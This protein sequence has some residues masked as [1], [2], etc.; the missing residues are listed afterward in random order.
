[1]I[2]KHVLL[3]AAALSVAAPLCSRA[4]T[5]D[6]KLGAWEMTTTTST[7][8]KSLPTETLDKLSEAQ[9][10][11][12]E[13][14]RQARAGV[15]TT[16]VS[17]DCITQA[18]LDQDSVI[19][20]AADARCR[21]TIISKSARSIEIEQT[22]TA[23]QASTSNVIINAESPEIIL[24]HMATTKAGSR[25]QVRVDIKGRWLGTSCAGITAGG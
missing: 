15:P 25:G 24:A 18:D 20:S 10:A 12:I 19:K 16:S 13:S 1:M 7:E 6:V 9:R 14:A 11:R 4:E 5:L 8:V 3:C 21:R 22:C 17:Q 2:T 23:P